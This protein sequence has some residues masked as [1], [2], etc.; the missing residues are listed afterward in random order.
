[1]ARK[2]REKSS[3]GMYNIILKSREVLFK[4]EEDYNFFITI[5]K[6]YI[7]AAYAF[8]LTPYYICL[9]VKESDKGISLD[10]KPLIT[11]YARYYNRTYHTPGKLFEDRFKSEPINDEKELKNSIAIISNIADLCGGG[12]TSEKA[13]KSYEMIEFYAKV[14]NVVC[15]KPKKAEHAPRKKTATKTTKKPQAKKQQTKISEEKKTAPKTTEQQRK[16]LPT[17]LL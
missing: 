6:D 14:C 4:N 15:D 8:A 2:A 11:K 16:N 12:R 7:N 3:T 9:A 13:K 10:M 17:W 5:L 1:M